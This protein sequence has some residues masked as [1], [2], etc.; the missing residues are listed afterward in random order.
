LNQDELVDDAPI[1]GTRLLSD[2][3]D[4]C[5]VA[6]LKL[7]GYHEAMEDCNAGGVFHH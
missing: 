4:R 7:A 3:Y 2:I 1:R 5:N 6:I